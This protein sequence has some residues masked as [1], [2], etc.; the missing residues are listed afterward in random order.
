MSALRPL[1]SDDGRLEATYLAF[2]NL[3]L[4]RIWLC[5]NESAR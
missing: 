3:A 1:F 4:I 2:I 5:A